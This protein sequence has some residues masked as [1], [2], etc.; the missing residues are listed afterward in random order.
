[1]T[2]VWIDLPDAVLADWLQAA[3]S[4]GIKLEE[5]LAG[6]LT[7]T[8]QN[9]SSIASSLNIATESSEELHRRRPGPE[10][11]AAAYDRGTNTSKQDDLP[12]SSDPSP[13]DEQ[14]FRELGVSKIPRRITTNEAESHQD[15]QLLP[16]SILRLLPVKIGIR[17]IA[18]KVD[19][20]GLVSD[21][22]ARAAFVSALKSTL[23]KLKSREGSLDIN[24]NSGLTA[25]LGSNTDSARTRLINDLLGARGRTGGIMYRLGILERSTG[26]HRLTSEG[27][28]LAKQRNPVLDGDGQR[29]L[30]RRESKAIILLIK[31]RLPNEWKLMSSITKVALGTEPKPVSKTNKETTKAE[32]NDSD[33][34]SGQRSTS[35]PEPKSI[36]GPLTTS[37]IDELIIQTA[38]H[39]AK[40]WT[41]SKLRTFRVAILGRMTELGLMERV[42]QGRTSLFRAIEENSRLI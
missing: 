23:S 6:A 5:L 16:A 9:S 13:L 3:L 1:M 8:S 12:Q 32:G 35:E 7:Q 21:S 18:M 30:T 33:T 36:D 22:D 28:A 2:K 38:S 42:W 39:N 31:K 41:E 4:T 20:S 26:G 40:E 27:L 10:E 25:G 14:L 11:I 19:G 15:N 24:K 37:T 17:S 34:E 29:A